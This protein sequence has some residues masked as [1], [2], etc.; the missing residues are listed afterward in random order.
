MDKHLEYADEHIFLAGTGDLAEV[1]CRTNM[2]YG[3]AK[4]H[5]F[6]RSI[7]LP[8]DASFIGAPDATVTRNDARWKSGFSY[9]GK[10][11]WS[12]GFAVLDVKP[13]GCGVLMGRLPHVPPKHEI[14]QRLERVI[15][16]G[17]RVDGVDIEWDLDR[18]NHFVEV[19]EPENSGWTLP[20]RGPVFLIHSSG[21]EHRGPTLHGPGLYW[22]ASEPLR[23]MALRHETP[24][25]RLLVLTGRNAERYH[26]H[27]REVHE[28]QLRRRRAMA[29]A[30]FGDHEVLFQ[31][32]H[33]GMTGPGSMALGSYLHG[34]GLPKRLCGDSGWFPLT[35]AEDRP[36]F[37]LRPKPSFAQE[38]IV[39]LG[40]AERAS[41]LG[42]LDRLLSA[43]LLPHG[44]GTALLAEGDISVQDR[45]TGRL[46]S[47]GDVHF[48]TPKTLPHGYRGQEVLE[49]TVA[50]ALGEV[51]GSMNIR[52]SLGGNL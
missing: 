52:W 51:I 14:R 8:E 4:I 44:G 36:I 42:L 16:Q 35:L 19:A 3:L 41:R 30:L 29:T 12:G 50:L 33:Q 43:N 10:L 9:G 11:E 39:R 46:F 26:R 25:G 27:L 17:V 34:P 2:R 48:E 22:D 7:G 40:W 21:P 47:V 1:L 24:W 18:S 15:R 31:A 32:M 20:W 13:N 37:L 38:T 23:K 28:F 45:P 6:Q 5:H 49:R